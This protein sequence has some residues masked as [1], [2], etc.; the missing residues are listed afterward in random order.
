MS[1]AVCNVTRGYLKARIQGV[2][3]AGPARPGCNDGVEEIVG[4]KSR[5]PPL[6]AEGALRSTRYSLLTRWLMSKGLRDKLL[7]VVRP[8]PHSHVQLL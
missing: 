4:S 8:G 6:K 7:A 3:A 2:G 5:T 1:V